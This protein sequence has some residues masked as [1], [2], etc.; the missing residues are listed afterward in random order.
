MKQETPQETQEEPQ[1]ER[2]R[3]GLWEWTRFGE[4]G[5]WDWLQLLIIPVMLAI[6]GLLFNWAQET[7]QQEAEERR[8]QSQREIEDQRAQDTALQSYLDQM[9]QLLVEEGLRKSE[10]G[11]EV[12]SAARAR[13]LAVL[14]GL[15]AQ[16]K[17]RV[18]RFLYES[19]L[20][21][22]GNCTF[23][24]IEAGESPEEAAAK[25]KRAFREPHFYSSG[26][27]CLSGG[28]INL[29]GA[30]LSGGIDLTDVRTLSE[31]DFS[32][33]D[34]SGVDVSDRAS[35]GA[36]L[37]DVVMEDTKLHGANLR[38]AYMRRATMSSA[39]L[40]DT[41]LSGSHLSEADLRFADLSGAILSDADLSDANLEYAN[42]SGANLSGAI[43][44]EEQLDTAASLKDATMPDGSKHD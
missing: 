38:G 12:R 20:V 18:V 19:G 35:P 17:G 37:D 13:T 11:D 6:G 1:R 29:D 31:A 40:A 33:A 9:S 36:N 15:D 39:E 27:L 43:V 24:Q 14:E 25:I 2:R 41:D 7:R 44:T 10:P 32:G 22:K 30:D 28:I 5:L 21:I 42:L 26:P 3:R 34:L 23:P 8:A 4:K 16:R